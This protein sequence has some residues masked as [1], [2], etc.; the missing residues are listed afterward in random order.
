MI[1]RVVSVRFALA[2]GL[3][4]ALAGCQDNGSVGGDRAYRPLSGEVLALM[5]Q[6]GTSKSAPMLIRTFKKEAEFE[7]WKMK[8]DGRYALLKT[9]PM[10]RWSGQLGPKTRE[11]DRQ[12]PEGFYAITPGQMNPNSNYYLSFNVGYPNAYDKAL[13]RGGGLIMVH[14]ACS[15]A[16]CFSM[17]DQQIAEIYSIA[18]ESFSG[19][20]RAIQM[21][22][23]PFRMTAENLA[24]HRL[25]PNIGF[26]KQLKQ[27]SD[28][29]EVAKTEPKVAVCGRRYVFDAAP[30]NP[31]QQ[32][33]A[34][35]LCPP[36]VQD[37][38]IER[39]VAAKQ[40]RDDTAVAEL[41]EKGVRAVRVMYADGGQHPDFANKIAE[42]SR[43]DALAQ[44]A[45][46]IA[47]DEG[48]GRKSPLVQQAAL[49]QL[50]A[51]DEVSVQPKA[52]PGNTAIRLQ[53]VPV[54]AGAQASVLPPVVEQSQP[55][56]YRR[57]LGAGNA[58][59]EAAPIQGIEQAV[60]V[61]ADVPLPPRRLTSASRKAPG[62]Q[63]QIHGAMDVVPAGIRA[64]AP[65]G[66]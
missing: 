23:L 5:E 40:R 35:G 54:E 18:R 42:T 60:P 41:V 27:G 12:V 13:G 66:E 50:P 19:G 3:A 33:D 57:W 43:P 52:A 6:K 28:H 56:F 2:G 44:G 58:A 22:S 49:R 64:Y 38:D 61:P 26:W 39:E 65:I 62:L 11:G 63:Q 15:S 51:L 34:G 55:A 53:P 17:T 25:D 45:V 1:A 29:F 4:L 21:E 37:P 7:I 8:A 30:A 47:L 36:L 14:G 9:F 46:E 16:G 31:S 24:K 59:E 20:Q 48:K 10:C 32:L